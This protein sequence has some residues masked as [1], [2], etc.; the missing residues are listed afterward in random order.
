[1]TGQLHIARIV[2]VLVTVMIVS[3]MHSQEP[4]PF[5]RIFGA[6]PNY[7]GAS[8]ASEDGITLKH[9]TTNCSIT[10][11]NREGNVQWSKDLRS[12]GCRLV[13]FGP[14]V[15]EEFKG[16]DV[17]LQFEDMEVYYLESRR[18]KIKH[19]RKKH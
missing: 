10:H 5:D 2:A 9:D 4:K 1:M 11:V 13:Y 19:L 17:L 15:E 14:A 12:Y 8:L 3:D 6:L 16:Y 18:G 7:N